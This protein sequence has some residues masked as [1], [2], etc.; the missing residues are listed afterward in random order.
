MAPNDENDDDETATHVMDRRVPPEKPKPRPSLWTRATDLFGRFAESVGETFFGVIPPLTPE[1][2]P[3]PPWR[4]R[5]RPLLSPESLSTQEQ[6]EALLIAILR[7]PRHY[8]IAAIDVARRALFI[9]ASG[10]QLYADFIVQF[11][12][13][14]ITPDSQGRIEVI[15]F[16]KAER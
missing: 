4:R 5:D 11:A 15:N 10:E 9:K 6:G 14:R 2:P 16:V 13:S 1:L 7:A 8:Q 12:L 3:V